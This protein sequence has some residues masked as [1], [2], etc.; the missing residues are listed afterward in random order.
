MAM[1]EDA[2]R[3]IHEEMH[4]YHSM[5][6]V[7]YSAPED[8]ASGYVHI[9]KSP[10]QHAELANGKMIGLCAVP[11]GPPPVFMG[12]A[13]LVAERHRTD[14]PATKQT[15]A[16]A[17]RFTTALEGEWKNDHGLSSCWT[18]DKKL[19]LIPRAVRVEAICL[20]GCDPF[21][22]ECD[23]DARLETRGIHDFRS[24]SWKRR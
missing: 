13:A 23:V 16:D 15:I 3:T 9:P 2:R 4:G 24:Y 14:G 1:A 11:D 19:L 5:C 7:L 10:E 22:T 8:G 12:T 18:C 17:Q 21:Y 20:G 6:S